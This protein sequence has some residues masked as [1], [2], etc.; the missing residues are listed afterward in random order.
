MTKDESA[1][2]SSLDAVNRIAIAAVVLALLLIA[3]VIWELTSSR[4]AA[5]LQAEQ[6]AHNAALMI[7]RGVE[8]AFR[9]A[10]LVLRDVASRAE[11]QRTLFPDPDHKHYD[12]MRAM[13]QQKAA[14]LPYIYGI[15]IANRQCVVSYAAREEP[16]FDI[17]QRPYCPELRGSADLDHYD[18]PIYVGQQGFLQMTKARK[19]RDAK[20]QFAGLAVMR[21]D[22]NFFDRWL[23]DVDVG[24]TGSVVIL[25]TDLRLA[26]RRPDIPGSIGKPITHPVT[27]QWLRE[28]DTSSS[29]RLVSPLD[30]GERLFVS[31]RLT[32]L[33][34][35]VVLGYGIDDVLADWTQ[36]SRWLVMGVGLALLL[37]GLA[38]LHY[39]RRLREADALAWR[40]AA[41]D[42]SGDAMLITDINGL[43]QHVNPAF[44]AI[45]GY[46]PAE[47]IGQ[48]PALMSSGRH[49]PE[50]YAEIWHTI[51]AG[52]QWRG[53]IINRRK[54]GALHTDLTTI[55]PVFDK[56]GE[57]VRFVAIQHEITER[58]RL[59][60]SLAHMA[61]TDALT[62][63]PNR[64]LLF[65]RLERALIESRRGG[66]AFALFFADLDGFKQINDSYGHET[67]DDLLRAVANRLID[68][69]RESDTVARMGGDEFAVI[70]RETG[71]C[72]NVMAIADKMIDA[73]AHPFD[74]QH[75]DLPTGA[76]GITIGVALY[77]GDDP[78]A[79]AEA[80]LRRADTAM[81]RAKRLG[82]N[83][84]SCAEVTISSSGNHDSTAMAGELKVANA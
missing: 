17:S 56:R 84:A 49:D 75:H 73:L 36:H 71:P 30:G 19:I 32:G 8:S 53:E 20:G 46:T 40:S 26:A 21:V 34:L 60:A 27:A 10:D 1:A 83:R 24:P 74:L 79:D 50:F 4:Q 29:R 6:R 48:T 80:I 15:G 16:G 59:E 2:G 54:D 37:L 11:P 66:T 47:A 41:I 31:R 13:L 51:R 69:V 67:G 52:R 38:T 63:L 9:E 65:D 5:L 12:D 70:L 78:D 58:K 42:A 55:S 61:H 28:A 77:P 62:S 33:P 64:A 76:I 25:D 57:V 3:G 81:Y 35:T 44:T 45:S 72:A 23:A 82:K 7:A 68:C 43:I 18:S 22:M 39:M 14:L